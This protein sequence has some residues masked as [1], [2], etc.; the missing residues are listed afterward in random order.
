MSSEQKK[1]QKTIPIKA[2]SQEKTVS[3]FEAHKKI[4]PRS[5][6][7]KF[8]NWRWAMVWLTQLFFYCLPWLNWR[9]V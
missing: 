3:F 9:S 1:P 5:I 7:G 6:S 8:M 2:E 4:Y